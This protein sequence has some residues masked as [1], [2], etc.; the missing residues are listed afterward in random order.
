[1]GEYGSRWTKE[2]I[3]VV[4][5]YYYLIPFAKMNKNHPLVRECA[6]IIGR[7]PS[8]VNLRLG[9]FGSFDPDLKA[10]DISGL[11]NAGNAVQAVWDAY[12]GN[13][14]KLFADSE[15]LIEQF[16]KKRVPVAEVSEKTG[17]EVTRTVQV[18][19]NQGVFRDMVLSNYDERCCITGM[20]VPTL[21]VASHIKPWAED[22]KNRL[23]PANGLCLNTL[24]DKAF[25]RGLITLDAQNRL[26]VSSELH[27]KAHRETERNATYLEQSFLQYEGRKIL[28]PVRFLP[29]P[30]LMEYHREKIFAG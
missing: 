27:S 28:T 13:F 12:Y 2:G 9:N 23:N 29:D 26:V 21:L 6:E 17:Y 7:T 1:M 16:Q 22:E 24:H 10:L 4:L 25:D 15:K 20:E 5:R 14:D 11:K 30:S 8:S 3:L 18:R 19:G